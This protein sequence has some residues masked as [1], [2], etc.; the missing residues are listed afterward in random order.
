MFAPIGAPERATSLC[1]PPLTPYTHL[2]IYVCTHWGPRQSYAFMFAP[3]WTPN[4]STSLCLHPLGPQKELQVSA[5]P[6]KG[7]QRELQVYV[8]PHWGPRESYKFMFAPIW[9][10]ERATSLCLPPLLRLEIVLK[11]VTALMGVGFS[12]QLISEVRRD[13]CGGC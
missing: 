10:P 13:C 2:Q 7:P 3:N 9:A 8:C 12:R 11:E 6:H 4:T 5:C 1:L